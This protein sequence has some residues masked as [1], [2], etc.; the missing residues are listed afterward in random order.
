MPYAMAFT[1]NNR[2]NRIMRIAFVSEIP[3]QG[4]VPIAFPNMRTECAWMNALNADH[5]NIVYAVMNRTVKDYDHVFVIFPKGKTYL[6]AE[7][8]RLV[9]EQN[10]V[11]PLITPE[12]IKLLRAGNNKKIHYVQEGP[13]WWFND[14]EINDQINFYNMLHECDSIFVHNESDKRYYQGLFPSKVVR[15]IQTLMIEELI[16]DIVPTKEAKVIIG[17][18]FARWYGGFESYRVAEVFNLPIWGQTSHA[19]RDN[20]D[21]VFKH[22]ER[23]EWNEWI[24]Q[25]SSFKYAVHLMPTV[26]AGTF[27]LNCA[28][29]GI[30]CIG[31]EDVDTQR[32]CHPDLSVK[33]S[34]VKEARDLALRL[35][36]DQDFYNKCSEKAKANYQQYY[37]L[38][39]W[40]KRMNTILN[41][42]E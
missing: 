26:A 21:Q 16:K 15:T 27:S 34:D 6:S 4:K 37:S 23:V 1:T 8:S 20:E 3:G 7:G 24:E 13:H 11:S 31:N 32:I 39:V 40:N 30:P 12:L 9:E 19:M 5:H 22:L 38:D 35:R 36:D 28:Y 29:L 14:Y 17:G 42:T 18:N 25:L 33:V 41:E 10:P 2:D